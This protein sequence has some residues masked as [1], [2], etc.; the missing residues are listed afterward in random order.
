MAL[1]SLGM[2]AFDGTE[3]DD[4]NLFISIFRSY[5]DSVN[6]NSL[7]YAANPTGASRAMGI[8]RSCMKGASAI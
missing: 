6:V 4:L 1:I 8:L 5:L 7:D 3:D 2:P